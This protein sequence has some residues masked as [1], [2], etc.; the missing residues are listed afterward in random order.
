MRP[1]KWVPVREPVTA[2]SLLRFQLSRLLLVIDRKQFE[3]LF[4]PGVRQLAAG[5]V[6]YRRCHIAIL[7]DDVRLEGGLRIPINDP[8]PFGL[9]QQLLSF[10]IAGG[11]DRLVHDVQALV[12]FL[13]RLERRF[14][15]L[16][17]RL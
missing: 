12:G 2:S 5:R 10:F 15:H 8:R 14:V 16:R 13:E 9:A 7:G 3:E 6:I 17:L 4:N 1:A 11:E